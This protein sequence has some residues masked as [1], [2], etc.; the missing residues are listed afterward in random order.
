MRVTCNNQF[1]EL[2]LKKIDSYIYKTY[3]IKYTVNGGKRSDT[4]WVQ[5]IKVLYETELFSHN[6]L[7]EHYNT[8]DAKIRL[9][10]NIKAPVVTSFRKEI[11]NVILNNEE[12]TLNC[13]PKQTKMIDKSIFSA[14][15]KSYFK[16][17]EYFKSRSWDDKDLNEVKIHTFLTESK[18]VVSVNPSVK[19]GLAY[20]VD[21]RVS[22]NRFTL[23]TNIMSYPEAYLEAFCKGFEILEE[24]L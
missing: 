13:E 3:N 10:F 1:R 17:L 23:T 14:Y 12:K 19:E 16:L 4:L 18:I 5:L 21:D 24:R 22:K 7:S 11:Y 15:P 8:T 20:T 6:V 9:L 2:L